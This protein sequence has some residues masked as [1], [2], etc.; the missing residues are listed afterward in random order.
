MLLRHSL[1]LEPEA[2]AVEQAVRATVE[3]GVL[4]PDVVT[5]VDAAVA[6]TT[7]AVVDSVLRGLEERE[8]QTASAHMTYGV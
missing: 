1:G 5:A 8:S 6:G 2:R 4:T 3:A 7:A